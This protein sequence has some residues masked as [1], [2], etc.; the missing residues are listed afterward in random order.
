MAKK[1]VKAKG[2]PVAIKKAKTVKKVAKATVKPV[3]K[4]TVKAP[5]KV[6]AKP[7]AKVKTKVI[8][9][10]VLKG[11]T[12]LPLKKTSKITKNTTQ[13][14]IPL[15]KVAGKKTVV[16]SEMPVMDPRYQEIKK[17]LEQQKKALLV[18][19][20][21]TLESTLIPVSEGF[22]DWT[23]QASVEVDQNCVLRLRE[24]EQHLL[25]KIEDAIERINGDTFGICEVCNEP[26]SI[27]RLKARPVTTL[28]I[29]CKTRQ[30]VEEKMRQ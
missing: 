13:K 24:R 12:S 5:V 23:D 15:P 28:C 11:K 17:M 3:V 7:V 22:P 26:I 2:S 30:E 19:A 16:K 1:I 10:T 14:V 6:V 29:E 20:G 4:A 27:K 9:K 18:E 21:A 8:P 25:N